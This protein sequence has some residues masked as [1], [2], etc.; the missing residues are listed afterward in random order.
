MPRVKKVHYAPFDIFDLTHFDANDANI[1]E[2]KVGWY[3]A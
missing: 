3:L 1:R 2:L